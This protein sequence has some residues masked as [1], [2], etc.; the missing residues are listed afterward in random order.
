MRSTV[1][2]H[3]ASGFKGIPS[4]GTGIVVSKKGHILTWSHVSLIKATCRVVFGDG[5]VHTYQRRIEHPELGV[6][7]LEPVTSLSSKALAQIEPMALPA[8]RVECPSGTPIL[9]ISNAFK[10]AEYDERLSVLFGVVVGKV[11]SDLRLG[12]RKFPFKGDV[13]IVDAPSGPGSHGGGLFSLDGKF[14]GLLTTLVESKETNTQL[15]VAVPAYELAAFVAQSTGDRAKAKSIVELQNKKKP[16]VYTGIRL[17]ETARK[18]SPPAYIDRVRRGSPA[19]KA[20]LRPDDLIVRINEFPIRTCAEFRRALRHFGPGESIDVTIK[21]GRSVR[22][23]A[24]KLVE[25][26]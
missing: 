9:A 21:R 1:K 11:R 22:K 4:Y 15:S 2:I 20:K 19:A 26:K 8:E 3:G 24:M 14:I 6:T 23:V 12:L 7:I 5:S 10:L 17:F 25:K 16:P 18:V 13:L